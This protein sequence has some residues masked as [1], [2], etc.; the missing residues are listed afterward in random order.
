M[1]VLHTSSWMGCSSNTLHAPGLL[2]SRM[3]FLMISPMCGLTHNKHVRCF[4]K[5]KNIADA[6]MQVLKET[7]SHIKTGFSCCPPPRRWSQVQGLSCTSW[8][9]GSIA[10]QRSIR[11]YFILLVWMTMMFIKSE[12]TLCC[13]VQP[14][15]A[16]SIGC[17]YTSIKHSR[18]V[19]ATYDSDLISRFDQDLEEY[20]MS[21]GMVCLFFLN[22]L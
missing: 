10:P 14:R 17:G 13:L 19:A 21:Y 22:K 11:Y 5:N 15:L 6:L 3:A 18:M 1:L 12:F 4:C 16:H 7:N 20:F 8:E 9:I 2:R